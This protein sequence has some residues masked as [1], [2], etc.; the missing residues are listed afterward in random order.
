MDGR[1][2][3]AIRFAIAIPVTVAAFVGG[4]FLIVPVAMGLDLPPDSAW[5]LALL[6]IPV[7]LPVASYFA[8]MWWDWPQRRFAPNV[9]RKCGYDCRSSPIRCPECGEVRV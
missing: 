6:L 7:V 4:M 3:E 9:C 5:I 8:I 1:I 2:I